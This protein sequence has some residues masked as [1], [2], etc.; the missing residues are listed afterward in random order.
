[1]ESDIDAVSR[2]FK[3]LPII[4]VGTTMIEL[5]RAVDLKDIRKLIGI[6]HAPCASIRERDVG[7]SYKSHVQHELTNE[8]HALL[9]GE[10][11]RRYARR[12]PH[13]IDAVKKLM[14]QYGVFIRTSTTFYIAL[15][16]IRFAGSHVV[17][18]ADYAFIYTPSIYCTWMVNVEFTIAPNLHKCYG[19]YAIADIRKE[20]FEYD[21]VT[22]HTSW[23]HPGVG[24]GLHTHHDASGAFDGPRNGGVTGAIGVPIGTPRP[25]LN[26]HDDQMAKTSANSAYIAFVTAGNTR[27]NDAPEIDRISQGSERGANQGVSKYPNASEYPEVGAR[28]FVIKFNRASGPSYKLAVADP[29]FN[30]IGSCWTSAEDE[31][32]RIEWVQELTA[33]EISRI[34]NRTELAIK[35]RL[36]QL[37]IRQR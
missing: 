9:R 22:S 15:R 10:I 30:R 2:W 35:A 5:K 36:A 8:G 18:N 14:K 1:M 3:L 20:L 6:G 21:L 27:T 33:H 11:T 7:E 34:H 19:L 16:P 25:S 37:G 32:L 24:R 4:A 23:N 17:T 12:G 31:Q 13:V 26:V 29:N 28:G